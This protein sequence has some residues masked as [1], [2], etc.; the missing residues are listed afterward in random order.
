MFLSSL[1]AAFEGLLGLFSLFGGRLG[2]GGSGTTLLD[3]WWMLWIVVI[4]WEG[5]EGIFVFVNFGVG[6]AGLGVGCEVWWRDGR[7]GERGWD[8]V[9]V[10]VGWG[11]GWR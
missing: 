5:G 2:W 3:M 8:G 4:E 6:G 10:G 1:C 7:E 11:W 9:G